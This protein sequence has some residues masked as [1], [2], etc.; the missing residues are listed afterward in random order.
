GGTGAYSYSL[1][2]GTPQ[3]SNVFSGLSAGSYTILVSDAKGCTFS[4]TTPIV[5]SNPAALSATAAGSS[6]VSCNNASDG[7]IT[8]T[9]V[10]GTGAYSYSLNGGTPQS[11]NVFSGLSAGSYTIVVSDAK[12][13]TFSISTPI[14]ISNPA[15][16]SATASGSAQ[17]SC[18]NASDGVITVTAVGGTG[19]YSYSLNGGTPQSSNVF[20]G[21]SAGSY[22][23]VVSDAKGCTLTLPEYT[24]A[25]PSVITVTAQY[26]GQVSC[27]DAS[28][29]VITVT[30][31]G[32]TG[33]LSYS[34]NGGQSQLSNVFSGLTAGIYHVVVYDENGCSGTMVLSASDITIQNPPLLTISVIGSSQVSCNDAF[35]GIITAT[36]NGGTGSYTYSLN[37]GVPQLSNVFNGLPAG[38]YT[39]T[40][41]DVYGCEAISEA[42]TIANPD[43]LSATAVGSSQVSCNNAGDGVI[44]VTAVG[45]TGVYSYS[46]NGGTAQSSNVFSGLSAGSYTILVSD[47]KGCTFSIST[48]IVISNPAALSA[49]AVGSAQVSCH[50]GGD[51]SIT[52]TAT[53]GTGAYSYSLNGGLAQVSNVFD[54]LAAGSYTVVVT[55]ANGCSF[56]IIDPIIIANPDQL[57]ATASGSSQ[58]SCNNASDGVIT[59]TA[60]GGTGSYSYSLNGG[61]AQSSNIFSGLASGSYLVSVN[62]AKGCIF[63]IAV[64]II[65]SNPDA[66]SATAV[67]SSQVS[68][69][70]SSDG[71]ITV[72]AVGG[73]G[74]YS[75]SLNGGIFQTSNVFNGLSAGSYTVVVTDANGCSFTLP[76]PVVI[77]NPAGLSATAAGSS[78]VSCNNASDGV[79]TVTAVGGTGAYSYSLNGGLAQLSNVFSGLASGTYS[80]TVVDENGCSVTT[81]ALTIANP[82]IITVT[83]QN[84]L[85]VSCHDGNDGVITI[86]ASGGTPHYTY[87]ING[88]QQQSSNVFSGLYAGSY[89][90]MVYDQN[91]CSGTI[92]NSG[93]VVTIA[94]P[95]QITVT[96]VS[97]PQV[98]CHDGAD[99]Q[100]TVTAAGG[101]GAYSY[102][103]NGGALQSTDVFSNLVSGTYVVT[104]FDANNCSVSTSPIVI[105]NPAQLTVSVSG[106]TQVSCHDAGDGVINV[107]AGGGTGAYSFSLNGGDVQSSPVFNNLIAGTYTV[108][109]FDANGCSVMSGSVVI[110]NPKEITAVSVITNPVSC[111][112]GNNGVITVSASGGTGSLSYSLNGG[113]LQTSNV[114]SFLSSGIYTI[115]VSDANGCSLVMEAVDLTNPDAVSLS[116]QAS[117]QVSCN[118]SND[119]VITVNASGGNG[120]YS[121]SLNGGPSQTSNVFSSLNAGS[122]FVTVY[123]GNLCMASSPEITIQDPEPIVVSAV[124]SPQV[125]CNNSSDATINVTVT[126]GTGSYSYSLNGG[127]FQQSGI[128]S[129]LAS[130]S[131]TVEVFDQN[132]CSSISSVMDILNPLPIS[133]SISAT[134]EV[135]CH[136]SNDGTIS[137]IASGGNGGYTYSLN[138]SNPSVTNVF[139]TLISGTYNVVVF[140]QNGCTSGENMVQIGNPDSLV[141]IPLQAKYTCTQNSLTSLN[142]NVS[143]GAQP[144]QYSIDGGLTFQSSFT[145]DSIIAGVYNIIVKDAKGCTTEVPAFPVNTPNPMHGSVDIVS[146]NLCNGHSDAIIQVNASDGVPP[147][148]YSLDGASF[149]SNDMFGNV[150]AG[151]HTVDIMDTN[152]CSIRVDFSIE[153][154]PVIDINLVSY[155]DANC[156]GKKDGAIEVA[157]DGGQSPYTYSWSTGGSEASVTNLDAG[158]YTLTITDNLGCKVEFT[159]PVLTGINEDELVINNV[160][161]PNAD[162]INDVWVIGN[163]DLYPENELVVLNRWGNEVFTEKS[164]H[165][166]WSGSRLLEGTY[167][168]VLK[169]KMCDED[170]TFQGYITIVR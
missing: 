108:T 70:N 63:S 31:S 37:G 33:I 162:G 143:G 76:S 126:G 55:D 100:I 24:I 2:G 82:T 120:V 163:I 11:S 64:P 148:S 92:D 121:Y 145:F 119:G 10:G 153:A 109:V 90:I 83:A 159:K 84:S 26:S 115:T 18:N 34:L 160:F 81:D 7:V 53:G 16:L 125:S 88:G 91:G 62:D 144:Y 106:S 102:S 138:G 50:N 130:G 13:C 68:C 17:V 118:T 168:Y 59:V 155:S 80:V 79:I 4:I 113:P 48:P 40:V 128:F 49:T 6:Q 47:A 23:I 57:S 134:A 38:T 116:V 136:N 35:D 150:S 32:G 52:V 45:G 44:T 165:N 139:S 51:A 137:I 15:G 3:S 22:T 151:N 71:S 127:Q 110:D 123:D 96:A 87:A 65:I 105:A 56:T 131:Y 8:V 41:N 103:L 72:T 124:G 156:A 86:F 1:N 27:H 28:D 77:A 78:Q 122:Y 107:V 167:F 135:S 166:D 146:G 99:G 30:A 54:H 154:A 111:N 19:A 21:L 147:Y 141:V 97:T 43:P 161:S 170:R 20:S 46:L 142:V 39:I 95:P 164:Y 169:V 85:Q 29:G 117:P 149:V 158:V 61:L 75:Y 74:A 89:Q 36:A 93:G 25:N 133:L 69:K 94:N 60:A 42:I 58:V 104:V 152:G 67:G 5:I 157:V 14:V 98:G 114:F 101:T 66:I 132:G 129:G 9:A 73:T 140:D 112:N 12:G